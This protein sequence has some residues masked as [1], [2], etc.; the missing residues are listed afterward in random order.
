MKRAKELIK[1][2]EEVFSTPSLLFFLDKKY[3][4]KDFENNPELLYQFAKLDDYD[5]ITAL[6]QW[7]NHKDFVLASLSKMIIVNIDR[8]SINLSLEE[9]I[10]LTN[11]IN[12]VCVN[13]EMIHILTSVA[14]NSINNLKLQHNYYKSKNCR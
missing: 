14:K 13:T 8:I 1:Y 11:E 9:F 2:G 5:I 12:N 10:L 4:K 7:A 3:I 6:K